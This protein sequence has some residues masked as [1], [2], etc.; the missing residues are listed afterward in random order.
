VAYVDP[1]NVGANLSAGAQ[2]GYQLVWVLVLAN[3]MACLV[4]YL[5]AK[6]GLVTGQSLPQLMAHQL[7]RPGRLAYWMQAELTAMATDLAEVVGGAIA[8]NLLFQLPLLLGG[9]ITGVVS[10]GL[11]SIQTRQGERRFELVISALLLII[12]LGFCAGLVVAPVSPPDLAAGLVPRFAGKDSII[13]AASM[14]G[15]TVMPHAVYLHSSLTRD[16]HGRTTDPQQRHRLIVAT[17]FDVGFSLL[18]AG[19]VNIGM[20]ILAAAC[21]PGEVHTDTINDAHQAI[22][23]ALGQGIGLA[24]AIGLLVSALASTSVGALAGAEVMFS[25]L[26]RHPPLTIRRI[27]TLVPALLA[28][29]LA[30]SPTWLLVISQVILSLTIPAALI[31]LVVLTSRRALMGSDRISPWTRLLAWLVTGLIIALNLGLVAMLL[32]G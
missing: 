11:L 24:F 4:Q 8:L 6:L 14:L 12:A 27:V 23:A 18:I 29:A 1:G 16:R 10:L 19:S 30:S 31:P 32:V 9:M 21:L 3:L 22:T 7:S 20:L 28:L 2:F 13:L 25:L 17:R 15:A 26:H 5:S